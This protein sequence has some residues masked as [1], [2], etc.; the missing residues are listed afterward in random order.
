MSITKRITNEKFRQYFSES[1]GT[2]HFPIALLITILYR[3]N[4][5]RIE[6]S[7]VLFGGFMKNFDST[8]ILN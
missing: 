5:R 1:S 8:K 2:V 4:H 6:K 3:Q 7:L